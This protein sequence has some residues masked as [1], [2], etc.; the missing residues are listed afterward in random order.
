MDDNQGQL[1]LH[2]GFAQVSSSSAQCANCSDI[3]FE[4]FFSAEGSHDAIPSISVVHA[5]LS[6]TTCPFCS[7]LMQAAGRF[8]HPHRVI[9]LRD[10]QALA[11]YF[12]RQYRAPVYDQ[13]LGTILQR[14]GATMRVKLRPPPSPIPYGTATDFVLCPIFSH[15]DVH[16]AQDSARFVLEDRIDL[17]VCREWLRECESQHLGDCV[18]PGPGASTEFPADLRVLDVVEGCIVPAAMGCRYVALSYVWGQVDTFSLQR[19]NVIDLET[20]GA[21]W[22]HRSLMPKTISDAVQVTQCLGER[23]LWID[24]LC[25][26]QDS[27]HKNSQVLGMGEIYGAAVLTLVAAQGSDANTGLVGLDAGS[28]ELKQLRQEV[29]PDLILTAS[30]DS[31]G[32]PADSVWASRGW[33]CQEQVISKRLLIFTHSQVMWQCPTSY[34]CED[35]A[36]FDKVDPP[37]RLHQLVSKPKQETPALPP[38]PIYSLPQPLLRPEAFSHYSA[39]VNDYSKR[40]FTFEDDVLLAFEGFG[41][42]LYQ[43]FNSKPLAGLPQA[44]FDQAIL[45][46]PAN[47]QRRREGTDKRFPSWSWAGWIG[48]V[49]YDDLDESSVE[50]V[51]SCVK[52]YSGSESAGFQPINSTGIGFTESSFGAPRSLNTFFWIPLFELLRDGHSSTSSPQQAIDL[53]SAPNQSLVQF[54]TSASF[55]DVT[56][57]DSPTV[58]DQYEASRH[59]PIKLHVYLPR[60]YGRQ[61][62]GYLVL[63]G[64]GPLQTDPSRHEFIVL[65]EAQVSGFNPVNWAWKH[66]ERCRMYNVMLVEWDRDCNIAYRLGIGRVLKEAWAGSRPVIKHVT[67][68]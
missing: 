63:N 65:S 66:S 64:D 62:A 16:E 68:G 34:L 39:I 36:A 9:P 18:C 21:L 4:A 37:R 20:P 51:V 22:E 28:R 29:W 17:A 14:G 45:W 30:I 8:T 5:N 43:A 13:D 40:N 55:L 61:L 56:V 15:D 35:T 33:T 26:I 52:W 49:R 44:Y 31:P 3:N 57:R 1:S 50:T 53:S 10:S 11:F 32:N 54:W 59:R 58:L 60:E 42:I 19:D 2:D 47:I 25:I 12:E 67:L 46:M 38:I 41:S 27:T 23:F 7:L 6:K 24:S 48:Q